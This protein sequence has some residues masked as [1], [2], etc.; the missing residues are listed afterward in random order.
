MMG[1]PVIAGENDGPDVVHRARRAL[2]LAGGEPDGQILE[3]TQCSGGFRQGRNP[4]L[5]L[6]A[7]RRRRWPDPVDRSA[8][9]GVPVSS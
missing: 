7:D 6:L 1:H 3:P 4:Q 2:S 9:T 5:G 8:H